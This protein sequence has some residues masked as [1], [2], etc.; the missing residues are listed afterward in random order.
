MFT[1]TTRR[2]RGLIVAGVAAT[3]FG[4]SAVAVADL[5]TITQFVYGTTGVTTSASARMGLGAQVFDTE[6]TGL[7]ITFT[8]A[9]AD[10]VPFSMGRAQGFLL[11][12][13]SAMLRIDDF[14]HGTSY[15]ATINPGQ[16]VVGV[17]VNHGGIGIG[18]IIDPIYPYGLLVSANLSDPTYDLQHNF[19][20]SFGNA[21]GISCVGFVNG[22]PCLNDPPNGPKYPIH[23]DQGDFWVEAQGVTNASISA[24]VT[25]APPCTQNHGHHVVLYDDFG[26]SMTFDRVGLWCVSGASTP[27][28]GP[29]TDRWIA[30]PFMPTATGALS[31]VAVAL[32]VNSGQNGAVLQLVD[33]NGGVPSTTVL[34]TWTLRHL[35]P[36]SAGTFTP[37]SV[38][39]IL[40]PVLSA[41][42]KY[43]L[44][45]KGVA[46][47]TL[48]TWSWNNVGV[49]GALLSLNNGSTWMTPGA[50][51]AGAFKVVGR[52]SNGRCGN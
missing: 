26:P 19:S 7:T 29:L 22:P 42:T 41:G 3:A 39:S 18:S 13:G 37:E 11:S 10:V 17:D 49:G 43:W 40:H 35:R 24:T 14:T 33:D 21:F 28:C 45:A 27:N 47:T 16:M 34:E 8:G 30:S 52:S 23:T 1:I 15:S 51:T 46:G 36:F 32:S 2:T 9:T 31:S 38:R 48:D 25:S 6:V 50:G 44:V 12:K 4:L 5:I 20:L